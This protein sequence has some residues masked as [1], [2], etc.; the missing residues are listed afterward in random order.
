MDNKEIYYEYK[1]TKKETK[2]VKKKKTNYINKLKISL[3]CL[4]LFMILSNKNTYKIADII[5]KIFRKDTNDII[6]ENGN[7]LIFG[8]FIIGLFFAVI[9]FI[10]N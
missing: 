8:T 3:Y 1:D 10:L 6:D 2:Q 7:P 9:I 4:I 5:V